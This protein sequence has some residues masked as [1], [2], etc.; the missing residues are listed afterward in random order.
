MRKRAGVIIFCKSQDKVLLIKRVMQD[1]KYWVVPGGGLEI[2]ESFENAARREIS[3]EIGYFVKELL[4]GITI[5]K[6]DS[7]EKYYVALVDHTYHFNIQGEEA[8][9]NNELNQYILEWVTVDELEKIN[10]LP[11]QL[12]NVILEILPR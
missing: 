5:S 6:E 10:L 2:D 11:A 7:V 4:E 1:M 8:K 12:K 3:E 9:R